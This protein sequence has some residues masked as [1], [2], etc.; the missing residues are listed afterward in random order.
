VLP[1]VLNEAQIFTFKF[2]FDGTLR[3]GM[4]CQNE[5]F[6]QLAAVDVSDRPKL[7]RAGSKLAQQGVPV[8]ISCS[9]EMCR[10]WGSLRSDKVRDLLIKASQPAEFKAQSS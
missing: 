7:Y 5:L 8:I 1:V 4:H 6:C 3:T 9:S 10:L 2:W